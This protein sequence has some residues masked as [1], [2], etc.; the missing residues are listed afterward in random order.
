[1]NYCVYRLAQT[2]SRAKSTCLDILYPK[3]TY[4]STSIFLHHSGETRTIQLILY[5]QKLIF[6]TSK[7]TC[8]L[9]KWRRLKCSSTFR[10]NQTGHK[11]FNFR[12]AAERSGKLD[13]IINGNWKRETKVRRLEVSDVSSTSTLK[14]L[15]FKWFSCIFLDL[16]SS[17]KVF[18]FAEV[19][20]VF[21]SFTMNNH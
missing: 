15:K 20:F 11:H 2:I 12:K 14:T 16:L 9:V 13:V 5:T 21:Y 6:N 17:N 3:C 8:S 10:I 18:I 19:F 1:M 7:K 4:I